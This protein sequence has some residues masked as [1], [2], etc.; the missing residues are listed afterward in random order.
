MF[1][2]RWATYEL[3]GLQGASLSIAS[4]KKNTS[5]SRR[6]RDMAMVFSADGSTPRSA[7]PG[8]PGVTW[9]DKNS[10]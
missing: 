2:V 5:L 9:S 7:S 8:K 4:S 6:N 10:C 1:A 3:V